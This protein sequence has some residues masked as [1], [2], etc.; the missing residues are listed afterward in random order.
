LVFHNSVSRRFCKEKESSILP[1]R[2][3]NQNSR[4]EAS[5]SCRWSF[6]AL[7]HTKRNHIIRIRH[8]IYLFGSNCVDLS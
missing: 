2:C 1:S 4:D 7:R 5:F 3:L 6:L 8:L